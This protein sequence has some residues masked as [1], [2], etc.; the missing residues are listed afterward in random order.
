MSYVQR[1]WVEAIGPVP[2]TGISTVTACPEATWTG[3]PFWL[4]VT[5]STPYV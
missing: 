2:A 5:S 4:T 1:S 3:C